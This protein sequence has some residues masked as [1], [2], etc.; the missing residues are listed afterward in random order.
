MGYIS[1]NDS[2]FS[3]H[4]PF[5]FNLFPHAATLS[6]PATHSLS[7]PIHS[8]LPLTHSIL[9]STRFSHPPNIFSHSLTLF[10]HP[11]A[12]LTHPISSPT[13]SLTLFF[14]PAPFSQVWQDDVIM[15]LVSD[16]ISQALPTLTSPCFT[17]LHYVGT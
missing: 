13:H 15:R 7:S 14:S 17:P 8:L 9:P 11:L 2:F 10:S 1:H 6:V 16:S 3:T 12:S 4:S 5:L